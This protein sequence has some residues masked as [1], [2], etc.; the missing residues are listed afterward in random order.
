MT[1]VENSLGLADEVLSRQALQEL[2][3]TYCQAVDRCDAEMLASLFHPGA[4]VDFGA[5]VPASEWVPLIIEVE[6]SLARAFHSVST[7]WFDIRGDK[8]IGERYLFSMI[9]QELDGG[10]TECFVGARYVGGYERRDGVWKFTF[11]ALI[12]DC[13]ANYPRDQ[14]W[15]AAEYDAARERGR[16][17][18]DDPVEQIAFAN[19]FPVIVATDEDGA[20]LREIADKQA[21]DQVI[22]AHSRGLDSADTA[23]LKSCYHPDGVVEYG[24]FEGAAHEF[25]E[26]VTPQTGGLPA[27][28]HRPSVVWSMVDGDRAKAETSVIV[29]REDQG[30]NGTLQQFVCGRYLDTLEKRD[31][32]WKILKRIYVLDW[33]TNMPDTSDWDDP[34]YVPIPRGVKGG[35][36][37]GYRLLAEWARETKAASPRHGGQPTANLALHAVAKRA[38]R[39]VGLAYCR[40]VDRAD[41]KLLASLFT[42]GARISAGDYDGDVAGFAVSQVTGKPGLIR[43]FH[44][45]STDYY[46]IDGD[47]ALGTT[48]VIR[49]D[50]ANKGGEERDTLQGGRFLDRF[51]REGGVWKIAERRYVVEWILDLPGT[52]MWDKGIYA[53]LPLHGTRGPDDPVYKFWAG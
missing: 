48:Y 38:L 2:N 47:Q 25:A 33:N 52:G 31:G 28:Q 37:A 1:V 11:H 49:F 40:A 29:Y 41:E 24:M 20:V 26:A 19:A 39:D 36:D 43:S 4:I 13:N 15:A 16:R 7:E 27:T 53:Q 3:A 5:P 10:G 34:L 18:P 22:A 9:T 32:A 17:T 12:F 8:A 50:T 35:D 42:K 30:D 44:S 46:E 6:L 21:I 45:I 23:L 14:F 51:E